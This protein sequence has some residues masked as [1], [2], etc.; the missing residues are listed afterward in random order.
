MA[1]SCAQRCASFPRS[2]SVNQWYFGDCLGKQRPTTV[3][4]AITCNCRNT[5]AIALSL[6]R[7]HFLTFSSLFNVSRKLHPNPLELSFNLQSTCRFTQKVVG[8][9][10]KA[11]PEATVQHTHAYIHTASIS[12]ICSQAQGFE[13]LFGA[14][15]AQTS[16][17]THSL[18]TSFQKVRHFLPFII[19]TKWQRLRP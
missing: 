7:N 6:A 8:L 19:G 14:Q 5:R 1:A 12:E 3:N 15:S 13:P 16:A 10:T 18:P 9:R 11:W 2:M 17:A 4:F